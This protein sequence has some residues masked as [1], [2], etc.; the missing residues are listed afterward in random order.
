MLLEYKF[1]C[2]R[3]INAAI[4]R[5]TALELLATPR[6]QSQKYCHFFYSV[7]VPRDESL[8]YVSL[9]SVFTVFNAVRKGVVVYI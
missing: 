6:G 2:T 5:L 9:A 4:V 1:Y 8:V 3:L 7:L